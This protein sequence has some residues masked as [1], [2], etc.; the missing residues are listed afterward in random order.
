MNYSTNRD[1]VF[2]LRMATPCF[3]CCAI[4]LALAPQQALGQRFGRAVGSGGRGVPVNRAFQP[5]DGRYSQRYGYGYGWPLIG[6]A[7]AFPSAYCEAWGECDESAYSYSEPQESVA[8][9][10]LV[11]YLRDGSGYGVTAY[12]FVDGV[13]HFVTTY[14]AEKSIPLDQLDAQRTVDQNAAVG[15]YFTLSPSRTKP[16][17][18]HMFVPAAP[19]CDSSTPNEGNTSGIQQNNNGG[20]ETL[21]I[22]GAASDTGLRVAE[23]QP[24]SIAARVGIAPGDVVV[25][26]DCR[27][28]RSSRDI[29]GAVR[30]NQNGILWV[31][32]L[33]KGTWL[34][35]EQLQLR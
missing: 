31:S 23:V 34:R 13:L 10:V 19:S 3:V 2:R 35:E 5:R 28:V 22:A 33:I 32:Y 4:A 14:G 17:P 12:W 8:G 30:E 21:G 20:P 11:L 25:K 27:T 6:W 24:G 15:L 18:K 26:I 29:D 7:A 16:A 1:N 9:P